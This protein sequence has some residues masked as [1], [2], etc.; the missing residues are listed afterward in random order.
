MNMSAAAQATAS[1]LGCI[2]NACPKAFLCD[3]ACVQRDVWRPMDSAPKDATWVLLRV[4]CKRQGFPNKRVVVGHWASDLSGS[5]QPSFQGWFFDDG[6]SFRDL[7]APTG[8]LPL[9]GEALSAFE[10]RV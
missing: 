10:W 6:Y 7:D 5:E 4:P 1:H 2:E 8:W 3:T 9:P